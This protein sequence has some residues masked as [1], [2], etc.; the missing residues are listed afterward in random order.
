MELET[1]VDGAVA[2]A[3]E[4]GGDGRWWHAPLGGARLQSKVVREKVA[5]ERKEKGAGVRLERRRRRRRKL[6][7]RRLVVGIGRLKEFSCGGGVR[8]F[9]FGFFFLIFLDF[10]FLFSW[11]V[12]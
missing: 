2:A 1:H 7:R 10:F 12:I 6:L 3:L 8:Q 4:E 11:L 9:V 5:A